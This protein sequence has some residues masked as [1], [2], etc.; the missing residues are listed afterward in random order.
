MDKTKLSFNK[1][2]EM[3]TKNRYT[4]VALY[5]HCDSILFIE[6]TSPHYKRIFFV[7]V[8][9]RHD[10]TGDISAYP[11]YDISKSDKVTVQKDY[12]HT[13]NLDDCLLMSDTITYDSTLYIFK[14]EEHVVEQ[15]SFVDELTNKFRELKRTDAISDEYTF[16]K[17]TVD[18]PKEIVFLDENDNVIDKG[19][20]LEK[21]MIHAEKDKTI[22]MIGVNAIKT[23]ELGARCFRTAL[24]PMISITKAIKTVI[25]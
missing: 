8:S 18:N 21:L 25:K 5:M 12:A 14:K 22:F 6:L 4:I 24:R 9:D 20:N 17:V 3:V 15:L 23:A 16:E 7:S 1:F 13:L 11:K 2:V 10:I 19:S